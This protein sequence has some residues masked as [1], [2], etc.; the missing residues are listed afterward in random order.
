METLI[1]MFNNEMDM[2]EDILKAIYL[3]DEVKIED[4]KMM[5]PAN[6]LP[7]VGN[8]WIKRV[9]RKQLLIT[10]YWK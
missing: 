3:E 10:D 1:E 9:G 4:M 2:S 8:E 6:I 5:T 7:L